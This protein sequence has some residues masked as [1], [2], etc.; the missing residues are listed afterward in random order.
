VRL[1]EAVADKEK[2]LMPRVL[3][4]GWAKEIVCRV[5]VASAAVAEELVS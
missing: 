3:F 4:D 5:L 2:G 1:E